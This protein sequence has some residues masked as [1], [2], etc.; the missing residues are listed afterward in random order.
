MNYGRL[1]LIIKREYLSMVAKKSFI[2]MTLLM[3]VL[4]VAIGCVPVLL[5]R[6]NGSDEAK[7]VAVVDETG[8]FGRSIEDSGEFEIALLDG[9]QATKAHE[10]YR[11][12]DGLLYAIVIIPGDVLESKSVT[13]YSEEAVS[14]SLINQIKAGLDKSLSE[15]KID[16]YGVD[17][18]A[19]IIKECD[20][21]V[22][23]KSIKWGEDGN[24]TISST[25][26]S[27]IVG[28]ILSFVIYMFVLM[29]GAMIINN[30]VEEKGNRI[31]EVIISSCKPFELMMGKIIGVGLVGLTQIAIWAVLLGGIGLVAG[32]AIFAPRVE[33]AAA[34]SG[35]DAL[36]TAPDE[37]GRIWEMISGVNYAQILALFVLYFIGGYLMYASLFAGFGSAVDQASDA[38]QFTMP[39]MVI[40]VFALYAGM[41]C[42]DNPDGQLAVWCSIIPFT[43]PIV[44][45][46]RLP[47]NVPLWQTL[48]SLVVLYGSAIGCI[49]LSSRI[50]RKG[51]LLY[52]QKRSF[53][54]IIRWI[55]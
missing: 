42:I 4:V 27:V 26:L 9:M 40:M 25:E 45:M 50:Y 24:E 46:T 3:P 29:Y 35:S 11:D 44:M 22:D 41:A 15:A 18:L 28:V 17:G 6:Y 16:A 53:G 5:S 37:M 8:I 2:L 39:I 54:E 31:V 7:R 10:Y 33:A 38:S 34:L 1:S 43:S 48:L 30:V 52:G 49:Y 36:S 23:V 47:F 51:I 55:K 32:T 19:D 13:V 12:A 20:V 21:D 14:M